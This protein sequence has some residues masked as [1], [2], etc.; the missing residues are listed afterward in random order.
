MTKDLKSNSSLVAFL[1][2]RNSCN[3][4][5]IQRPHHSV[6]EQQC[7]SS[8]VTPERSR[9]ESRVSLRPAKGEVVVMRPLGSRAV[10]RLLPRGCLAS[11]S[12]VPGSVA[13]PSPSLNYWDTSQLSLFSS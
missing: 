3:L 8:G 1:C 11:V 4:I 7:E 10:F 5:S 6:W 13:S 9:A 2:L 12:R